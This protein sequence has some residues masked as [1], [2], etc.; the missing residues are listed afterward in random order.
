MMTGNSSILRRVYDGLSMFA[1]LNLV[2]LVGLLALLS[3][4]GTINIDKVRRIVG[5]MRGEEP[6]GQPVHRLTGPIDGTNKGEASE[7]AP[8]TEQPVA[9]ARN[10]SDTDV[11]IIRLEGERIKTELDQRLALNNSILLRVTTERE[12]F[13][14]ERDVAEKQQDQALRKRQSDGFRKQIAIYEALSPKVAVEHLL[15]LP[16]LDDAAVIFLEMDTRKAKK[17]IEAAKRPDQKETV[18][19]ILRRIREIEPEK[20]ESLSDSGG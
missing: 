9:A 4:S 6:A 2:G 8:A 19:T 12:R 5:V 18:M 7:A 14:R 13:Q 10:E 11:Q 20:F 3:S 15:S 17:I 1:L 16:D